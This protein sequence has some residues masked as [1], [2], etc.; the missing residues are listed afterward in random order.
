MPH[1]PPELTEFA[2][3][4]LQILLI[5]PLT[6]ADAERVE[7]AVDRLE[8]AI[9]GGDEPAFREALRALNQHSAVRLGKIG[10]ERPKPVESLA[11]PL[12]DRMNTLITSL[13]PTPPPAR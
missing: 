11:A 3:T 10:A 13:R 9:R 2:A 12:R 8:R 7:A 5:A 4:V 6:Q 1:I